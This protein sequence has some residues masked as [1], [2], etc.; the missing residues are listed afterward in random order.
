[1]DQKMATGG[2]VGPAKL[3]RQLSESSAEGIKSLN[4]ELREHLTRLRSRLEMQR[5]SVKQVHWQ[6]V[7]TRLPSLGVPVLKTYHQ[8][9]QF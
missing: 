3:D 1:M 2:G 5:G 4:C 7:N 9:V 6:K 8:H